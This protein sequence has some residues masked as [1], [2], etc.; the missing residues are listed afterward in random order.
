MKPGLEAEGGCGEVGLMS[1]SKPALKSGPG[2]AF[3]CPGRGPKE[4]LLLKCLIFIVSS[5]QLC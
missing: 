1:S 5:L 4:T 2:T 3:G